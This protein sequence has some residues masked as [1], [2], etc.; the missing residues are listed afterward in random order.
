MYGA[1]GYGDTYPTTFGGKCVAA[2]AMM[3]GVLVIAFPVS[4]FSDLWSK[5]LKKQ[6][7]LNELGSQE[8][9]SSS[10]DEKDFN[11]RQEVFSLSHPANS[12]HVLVS[13]ADLSLINMQ[14]R[15]ID[16]AQNEIRRVLAKYNDQQT[17]G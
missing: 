17:G 8:L 11:K 13:K 5:E 16:E 4:V 7:V 10:E 3:M 1:V 6:G 14:M 2:M 15:Q 12:G 9:P